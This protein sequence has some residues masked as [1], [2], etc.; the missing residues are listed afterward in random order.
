MDAINLLT[1]LAAGFVFGG[2][3]LHAIPEST[4]MFQDYLTPR[5]APNCTMVH[6]ANVHHANETDHANEMHHRL[7][8]AS[9]PEEKICGEASWIPEYPWALLTASLVWLVLVFL[10]RAIVAHGNDG[11][12]HHSHDHISQAYVN[13]QSAKE[14]ERKAPGEILK[15]TPPPA[16]DAAAG[17][18]PL[19]GY[20]VVAS[21][22]DH[23]NCQHHAVVPVGS[24]AAGDKAERAAH[25]DSIQRAW[26]FFF[27][28][29]VHSIFDGLAVGVASSVEDFASVTVAVV[30]HKA[31][32]VSGR[33][34]LSPP[35][36][37]RLS[38]K[39]LPSPPPPLLLYPPLPSRALR[40]ACP[41]TW[42]S[43][44]PCRLGAPSFSVRS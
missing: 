17:S 14:E 8:S 22:V 34:S 15:S 30:A 35:P 26:V 40:W 36:G 32:D 11:G 1:A 9:E 20:G 38:L 7:L 24:S 18:A 6:H 19:P 5:Y 25:R 29:S 42:P 44:P 21:S 23:S 10:D 37:P 33:A 16:A 27:V 41:F 31:F 43:C 13:M 2:F 4:H 28:L 39:I 3:A 12:D